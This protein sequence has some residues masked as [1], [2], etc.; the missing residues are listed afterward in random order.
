M[1]PIKYL[2]DVDSQSIFRLFCCHCCQVLCRLQTW[3]TKRP[4]SNIGSFLISYSLVLVLS[5]CLVAM[6]SNSDMCRTQGKAQHGPS[7]MPEVN[8]TLGAACGGDPV[9]R[10]VFCV[11]VFIFL[12][13]LSLSLL[14]LAGSLQS[15]DSTG[16]DV[17]KEG[18]WCLGRRLLA[19]GGGRSQLRPQYKLFR[20]LFHIL[21]SMHDTDIERANTLCSLN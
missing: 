10:S 19:T 21:P 18:W 12:I 9:V 1:P 7:P 13:D 3:L 4:S 2:T 5:R 11:A 16:F 14:W 15:W 8:R 6:L 17:E 20:R